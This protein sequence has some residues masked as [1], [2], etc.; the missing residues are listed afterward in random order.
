MRER[1]RLLDKSFLSVSIFLYMSLIF[2]T[3]TRASEEGE[4]ELERKKKE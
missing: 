4:K 2:L 1:E 3:K